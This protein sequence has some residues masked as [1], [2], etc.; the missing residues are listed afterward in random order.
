MYGERLDGVWLSSFPADDYIF[1][2][3]VQYANTGYLSVGGVP[4]KAEDLNSREYAIRWYVFKSQDDAWHIDGKLVKKVG[5]IHVYKTFAGNKELIA[6]AKSDFY[7]DATDV[8]TGV[9]TVLNLN[10]YTSY[11]AANDKYMWE[12]TDVD[13]GDYWNITEH[14]HVF[15]DSSVDFGVYSEYTVMDAHGDQ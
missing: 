1:E 5:L 13:Y 11:D 8:S 12:I 15:A 4:V 14:P 3:L 2:S 6:E 7:I 9:N 10:N